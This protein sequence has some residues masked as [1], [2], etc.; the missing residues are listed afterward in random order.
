MSGYCC[1]LYKTEQHLN[2]KKKNAQNKPTSHGKTEIGRDL[3]T[4]TLLC[5]VGASELDPRNP[6][7]QPAFPELAQEIRRG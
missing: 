2:Q 4:L 5:L 3:L 1:C 7:N 6:S